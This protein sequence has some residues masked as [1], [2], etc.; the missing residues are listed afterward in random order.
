M[1]SL[2]DLCLN[3]IVIGLEKCNNLNSLTKD[4]SNK[5]FFKII[6]TYPWNYAL[7]LLLTSLEL[8][9]EKICLCSL[10]QQV[11]DTWL[12]LISRG[13]VKSLDLHGCKNVTSRGIKR[14]KDCSTSLEFLSLAY[15]DNISNYLIRLIL[16]KMENLIYLNLAGCSK[17][18]GIG[19]IP[20]SNLK[21]LRYLNIRKCINI[22][23]FP[24]ELNSFLT[25]LIFLDISMTSIKFLAFR[26]KISFLFNIKVLQLQQLDW[27][28]S[29]FQILHCFRNLEKLSVAYNK[30]LDET[31]LSSLVQLYHLTWIDVRYTHVNDTFIQNL[32]DHE[33]VKNRLIGID[34]SDTW[35]SYQSLQYFEDFPLLSYLYIDHNDFESRIE[36]QEGQSLNYILESNL[37][38]IK[39]IDMRDIS[40]GN[41][42]SSLRY[43]EFNYFPCFMQ[44]ETDF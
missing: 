4:L 22:E 39:Y 28:S 21:K 32:H 40:I 19:L 26:E 25:Q 17:I 34:L 44:H 29:A 31:S 42:K 3:Q 35:I 15:C 41:H 30:F 43:T 27:P 33:H 18:H 10:C 16:G 12:S 36:S 5:L 38:H 1:I 2:Q 6:E 7:F 24:D 20:L 14:L 13:G 23:S 37:A 8:R 11:T 9:M